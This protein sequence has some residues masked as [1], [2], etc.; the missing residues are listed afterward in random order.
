MGGGANLYSLEAISDAL[1]GAGTIG[2]FDVPSRSFDRVEQQV[3]RTFALQLS[4]ALKTLMSR[5]QAAEAANPNSR[6]VYRYIENTQFVG[7]VARDLT[8]P[9]TAIF[10]FIDLLR[11]EKLNDQGMIYLRKL[12]TQAERMQDIVIAMHAAPKP[13][14]NH[15]DELDR[16][17]QM[18]PHEI[19]LVPPPPREA[20]M[21]HEILFQTKPPVAM[22]EQ[23]A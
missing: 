2:I 6:E 10:G 23:A 16:E 12:Q 18:I 8:N 13:P 11:S 21:P 9:L 19:S 22:E 4:Y 20:M 15:A 3:L 17:H 7:N 1:I 14:R 5:K